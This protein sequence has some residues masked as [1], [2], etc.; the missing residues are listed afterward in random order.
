M[1][2]KN[3]PTP[4][5]GAKPVTHVAVRSRRTSPALENAKRSIS[6]RTP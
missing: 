1:S 4:L 6:W 3:F 2:A 5:A